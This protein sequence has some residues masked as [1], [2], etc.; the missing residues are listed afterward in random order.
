MGL[1]HGPNI[2]NG[3]TKCWPEAPI[4]LDVIFAEMNLATVRVGQFENAGVLAL[5]WKT[6]GVERLAFAWL[7]A[8]GYRNVSVFG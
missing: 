2:P 7:V 1:S 5:L 3:V 4:T 6:L 8:Q